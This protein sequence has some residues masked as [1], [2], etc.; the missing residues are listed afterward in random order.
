MPVTAPLQ[1]LCPPAR[2]LSEL[3]ENEPPTGKPPENAAAT[4]ATPWPTNSRSESHRSRSSAA[5]VRAIEPA[6]AYPTTAITV[7]ETSSAGELAPRQVQRER[8]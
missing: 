3:R 2:R 5:N 6:S 4:F 7:P 1:R 8:R